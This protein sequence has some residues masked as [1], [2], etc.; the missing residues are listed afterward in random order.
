M[1]TPQDQELEN[2]LISVAREFENP[3]AFTHAAQRVADQLPYERAKAL[4]GY[5]HNNPPEPEE[6]KPQISKYG[7]F[8]VWMNICQ[9]AIFEVLHLY[10]AQAIPLLYKIGFGEYDWTQYKAIAALCRMANNG[11]QTDE[12]IAEIGKKIGNFRYEAEMPSLEYLS[13]IPN[14]PE[15]PQIL[16]RQYQENKAYD[17]IDGFYI[18]YSLSTHYPDYARRELPFLKGLARGTGIEDRS[19]ILDGAVLSRDQEGNESF[20]MQGEEVKG[21]FSEHHRI[22]AAVLYYRLDDQDPEINLLLDYWA[23]NATKEEVRAY[24]LNLRAGGAGEEG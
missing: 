9:D 20:W 2:A 17:P 8:G 3:E 7:L 19:P 18:L 1:P 16:L 11:I 21:N 23:E 6:L 10:G 15:V 13:E 12:I 22:N 14:H 4:T 24:L 5:F